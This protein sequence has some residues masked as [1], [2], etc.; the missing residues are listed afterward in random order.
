[1]APIVSGRCEQPLQRLD[2]PAR[3]A[4][5][6][7]RLQSASQVIQIVDTQMHP[8]VLLQ[9]RAKTV[10]TQDINVFAMHAANG[11]DLV[12]LVL[13]DE[14]NFCRLGIVTEQGQ[15]DVRQTCGPA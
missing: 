9:A 6:R 11:L 14:L 12:A 2:I 3:R 15:I 10:Q 13:V 5:L 7:V 1:M 8:D 4:A